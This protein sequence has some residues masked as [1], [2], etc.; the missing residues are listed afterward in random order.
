MADFVLGTEFP[1]YIDT[2]TAT[3]E[4]LEDVVIPGTFKLI[5]CLASNGF[6]GTTDNVEASSKCAGIWKSNIAGKKGWTISGDGNFINIVSPDERVSAKAL[7]ALWKSGAKAWFAIF[8]EA[9]ETMFYGL[10]YISSFNF[11]APDGAA[12][13]F[14]ITVTGDGEPGNAAAEA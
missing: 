10:G 4:P 5:G 1:L 12:T 14:S 13:T 11:A 6:D 7:F 3:T 9:A 2:T 8:D